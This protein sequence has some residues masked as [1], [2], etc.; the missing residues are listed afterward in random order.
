MPLFILVSILVILGLVMIYDSSISQA[1]QDFG[2]SY[3]YIRQQLI[4]LGVGIISAIFFINFNYLKLQKLSGII[5][6]ISFLML[7]AVFI[8]GLGETVGGARRWLNL[9]ILTIQPAEVMKLASIIWFSSIFAKKPTIKHLLILDVLAILIMAFL[10]KDF[11]STTVLIITSVAIFLV[12]GGALWKML[13]IGLFALASAAALIFSA[14]YRIKRI[15]AFLDPFSDPRGYSY[16]ISQMLIAL[17]SGGL[18]G[19]GL[20]QSRQKFYIPEVSTDSIFA[21]VGEEL[22]LLGATFTILLFAIFII[23]GLKI[24]TDVKD[25]FGQIMATGITVWIG[26]QAMIN[27]ASVVAFSPLTGLPLPFISYGGSAL[28]VNLTAVGIL[29]N[30]S[31]Q[32]G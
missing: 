12:A 6:I 15:L 17:G 14:P 30:I 4:W 10:Q 11:G 19:L 13:I 1:L 2:D 24:A 5:L 21:I 28:V 16:H 26:V 20:G 23:R 22:G 31:K 7:L 3:Y 8:P 9:G 29:L 18:F 27:M 32:S 25:R